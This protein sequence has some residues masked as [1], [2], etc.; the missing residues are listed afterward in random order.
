MSYFSNF[1]ST[2]K[3]FLSYHNTWYAIQNKFMHSSQY[4]GH[5]QSLY[6]QKSSHPISPPLPKI[7][8]MS[9]WL[10]MLIYDI[11]LPNGNFHLR[12]L[13]LQPVLA[14]LL[15]EIFDLTLQVWIFSLL[16]RGIKSFT[17]LFSY[18]YPNSCSSHLFH[19]SYSALLLSP[20]YYPIS[21]AELWGLT[22]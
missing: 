1:L 22:L 8:N 14:V 3:L 21:L 10:Y 19:S 20:I 13:P 2:S 4:K 18:S 12:L 7:F 9:L 17:Q 11:H 16:D 6:F 15:V 5:I